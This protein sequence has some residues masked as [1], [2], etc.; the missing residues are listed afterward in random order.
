MTPRCKMVKRHTRKQ[1]GP[2]ATCMR[3]FS[4]QTLVYKYRTARHSS[5]LIFL[6]CICMSKKKGIA[7]ACLFSGARQN[8]NPGLDMDS[9]C[10]FQIYKDPGHVLPVCCLFTQKSALIIHDWSTVFFFKNRIFAKAW[11]SLSSKISRRLCMAWPRLCSQLDIFQRRGVWRYRCPP[12]Q[13]INS[14]PTTKFYMCDFKTFGG[15]FACWLLLHA[16]SRR[17]YAL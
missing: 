17:Q 11:L 10:A 14:L 15:F 9:V 13:R 4:A 8:C 16:K 3:E 12:A 2:R 7:Y 1:K 6:L 5:L